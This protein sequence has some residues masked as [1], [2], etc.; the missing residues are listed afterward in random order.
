[1]EH[2]K[3]INGGPAGFMWVK[4]Y[5]D[6]DLASRTMSC[7]L[8]NKKEVMDAMTFIKDFAYD[9]RSF[10]IKHLSC[11]LQ[12]Q[13]AKQKALVCPQTQPAQPAQ[14][15]QT[16]PWAVQRLTQD[17]ASLLQ[18]LRWKPVHT[19]I[20]LVTFAAALLTTA[21]LLGIRT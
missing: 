17:K 3:C 9:M 13:L 7:R 18:R 10:E 11:P 2:E 6:F 15:K 12:V 19:T 4:S 20:G 1:M 14:P 5:I 21:L 16:V 8:C